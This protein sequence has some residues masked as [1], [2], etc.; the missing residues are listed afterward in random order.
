MWETGKFRAKPDPGLD[1]ANSLGG[2]RWGE[3]YFMNL[4]SE[5]SPS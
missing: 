1:L 5:K 4:L 2:V 3:F